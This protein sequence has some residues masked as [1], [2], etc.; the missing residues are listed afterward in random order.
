MI[1]TSKK[2]GQTKQGKSFPKIDE[3]GEHAII[4]NQ[5]VIV[6]LVPFSI[7]FHLI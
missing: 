1:I 3:R 7:I 6:F 5:I 4:Q 2:S